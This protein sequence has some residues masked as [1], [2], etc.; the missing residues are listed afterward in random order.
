M[1]DRGVVRLANRPLTLR[2]HQLENEGILTNMKRSTTYT[3]WN[4]TCLTFLPITITA[5]Y[6]NQILPTMDQT[7]GDRWAP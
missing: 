5:F 7:V 4:L 2:L 3:W 6:I 1:D